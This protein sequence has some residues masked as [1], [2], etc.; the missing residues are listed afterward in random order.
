MSNSTMSA[1]LEKSM[2]PGKNQF[3]YTSKLNINEPPSN[4]IPIFRVLKNNG[5][6]MNDCNSIIVS[7]S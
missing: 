4:T 5:E 3:N 1:N 6:I 7:T 2:Y